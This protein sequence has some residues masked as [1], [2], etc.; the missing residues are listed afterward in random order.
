MVV[1]VEVGGSEALLPAVALAVAVAVVA[2]VVIVLQQRAVAG[3]VKS[4]WRPKWSP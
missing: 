4:A 2:P 3:R 1:V